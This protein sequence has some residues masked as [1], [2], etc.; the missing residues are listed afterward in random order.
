MGDHEIKLPPE[1]VK[2]R[3][4]RTIT[5]EHVLV[6]WLNFHIQ[7]DGTNTAEIAPEK[8]QRKCLDVIREKAGPS[9]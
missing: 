1:V 6:Q 4:G 8:N 2:T 9:P 5:M 3:N 7:T